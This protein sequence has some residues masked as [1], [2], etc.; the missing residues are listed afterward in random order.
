MS[1]AEYSNVFE[2]RNQVSTTKL[3][4]ETELC[5][6]SSVYNSKKLDMVIMEY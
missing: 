6:M 4:S 5:K 1:T 2:E 3:P